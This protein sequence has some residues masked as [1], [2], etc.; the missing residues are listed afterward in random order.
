MDNNTVTITKSATPI[1]S[2]IERA[3]SCSPDNQPLNE[4]EMSSFRANNVCPLPP[5]HEIGS[6]EEKRV[7]NVN[8]IKV[9]FILLY[10]R[11]LKENM[12]QYLATNNNY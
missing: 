3:P 6:R 5:I 9:I 1:V 12:N 4:Q 7:R 8:A 2:Q 11:S 10:C